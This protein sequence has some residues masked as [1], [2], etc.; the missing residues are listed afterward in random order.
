[1]YNLEFFESENRI[2]IY[3]LS[4]YPYE[5]N[6]PIK[7]DVE[8]KEYDKIFIDFG[9]NVLKPIDNGKDFV[10]VYS[11]TNIGKDVLYSYDTV[12]GRS[13]GDLHPYFKEYLYP[14]FRRVL[15]TGKREDVFIYLFN[16]DNK[17][18]GLYAGVELKLALHNDELFFFIE[19]K[20]QS[21][22]LEIRSKNNFEL[23]IL[24]KSIVQNGRIVK[25]NKAHELLTNVSIEEANKLT[26]DDFNKHKI[27]YNDTDL[28]LNY[29]QIME[30]VETNEYHQIT[31]DMVV[32]TYEKPRRLQGLARHIIFQGNPAVEFTVLKELEEFDAELE[33]FTRGKM[34]L[35][36]KIS[37]TAFMIYDVE[38]NATDWGEGLEYMLEG[39]LTKENLNRAFSELVINENKEQIEKFREAM[40]KESSLIEGKLKIK[41]FKGN[42]KY[43][44]FTLKPLYQDGKL[45]KWLQILTDITDDVLKNEELLSLNATVEDVQEAALISIHYM[46]PNGEH[47]WTP[48]TYKLLEREPR[49]E[50]KYKNIILELASPE[51]REQHMRLWK[52]L[53]RN[54]FLGGNILTITCENGKVKH[55]QVDTRRLY[56]KEGNF[57]QQN[58][59]AMDIT[60]ELER[61]KALIKSDAEKTVLI[62]EIHH[63]IKNNLQTINSLISLEERF[64]TSSDD[65]IDI[66][67]S[68]IN[69]LALIHETIYN[70]KI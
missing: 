27:I 25:I 63:R 62:K 13:F 22:E 23:S 64:K 21:Y 61:E 31:Y 15:N 1:M 9:L 49:E 6:A 40:K 60:K 57:I 34:D 37:K 19:N 65:I 2:E 11:S 48:E 66:T 33:E 67:K 38:K 70:E 14:V 35:I 59:Y 29:S 46:K 18:I 28:V 56:D 4:D 30:K 5:I 68:R 51:D 12:L 24:P 53:K 26:F 36:Q 58:A 54:E 45:I 55:L 7:L 8:P 10:F 17:N 44:R 43:I 52:N 20:T 32:D 50:D 69:S 39:S 16:S 42:I 3:N 47:V 41:T